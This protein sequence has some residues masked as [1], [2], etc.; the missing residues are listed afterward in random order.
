MGGGGSQTGGPG[1]IAGV[2]GSAERAAL[3]K[4]VAASFDQTA[5]ARAGNGSG[6]YLP[7]RRSS[8]PRPGCGFPRPT[9]THRCRS[10]AGGGR[11]E[12]G[13]LVYARAHAREGSAAKGSESRRC[14]QRQL[15]PQCSHPH[16]EIGGRLVVGQLDVLSQLGRLVAT[17]HRLP[18]LQK[19]TAT[20][21][22]ATSTD[23]GGI[24]A[25]P[26][27]TATALAVWAMRARR[28]LLL[29]GGP[30]RA[31]QKPRPCCLLPLQL[32]ALLHVV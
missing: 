22:T 18:H 9:A 13:E 16:L 21:T 2:P 24:S 11:G 25:R 8:A 6:A 15:E 19:Q 26:V 23:E 32:L 28:Q 17:P 20:S 4:A 27:P 10:A 31:N 1:S 5:R 12:W 29:S 7:T 14:S 3:A 30:S